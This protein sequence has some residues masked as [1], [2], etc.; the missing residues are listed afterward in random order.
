M[1]RHARWEGGARKRVRHTVAG[2]HEGDVHRELA[3]NEEREVDETSRSRR[4]VT[5]GVAAETIVELLI[6]GLL[7]NVG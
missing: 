6:I 7:A 1:I 3:G 2:C 5:T 4:R